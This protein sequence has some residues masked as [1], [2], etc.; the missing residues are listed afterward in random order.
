MT[1][2]S[3]HDDD[4]ELVPVPMGRATRQRLVAFS[5]AVGMGETVAAGV[6]LAD[7]LSDDEFWNE[8]ARAA[9]TAPLQ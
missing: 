6:L 1:D 4:V 2:R 3:D 5:R 7:I 9:E 8:A